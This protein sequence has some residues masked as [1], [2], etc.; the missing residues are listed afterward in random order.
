MPTQTASPPLRAV[1]DAVEPLTIG[2]EEEVMLLDAE[3]LQLA[4]RAGELLAALEGDPR[5]KPELPAAHVELMTPV[6]RSVPEALA[7]LGAARRDLRHAA[8]GLGLVLM[9]AGVHPF[10]PPTGQLNQSP[11]FDAVRDRYGPIADAQ[12]LCG[13]HVHVAVGGA[14]ATIAVHDMLRAHLPEL[15]ALA[16]AAPF[17]AGRD[18]GLASVR[19]KIAGLLPRQGVPPMLG[20]L[21]GFARELAW[22]EQAGALAAARRWWWELR[23][24]PRLG[25]LEVRV[26][27]TQATLAETGALAATIHALVAWLRERHLAGERAE[28]VPSWRIDENRWSACRHGVQGTMADLHAGATEPTGER[29]ERLLAALLPGAQRLGCAQALGDARAMLATGGPAC[30]HRRLAA[31]GGLTGLAAALCER[32]GAAC[33]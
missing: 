29:L 32:F 24:H 23:P 1:F 8:A 6:T 16:A 28:P 20:D 22:G 17:Y 5:F 26:C 18:S 12:L 3:T 9:G 31:D 30:A 10:S 13:L 14:D 4:P 11:R 33:E 15:A 27:D 25:T 2:V 7:H 21:A 19:P